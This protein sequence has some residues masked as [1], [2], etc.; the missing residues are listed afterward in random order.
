MLSS[1]GSVIVSDRIEACN[2][3][4]SNTDD[5]ELLERDREEKE[6]EFDT[7]GSY[8]IKKYLFT[9]CE[10]KTKRTIVGIKRRRNNMSNRI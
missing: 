2:F 8:R 6:R 5:G 1:L 10:D 4:L 9:E 7:S 3:S